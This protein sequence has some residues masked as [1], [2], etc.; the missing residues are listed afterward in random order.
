MTIPKEYQPPCARCASNSH[1]TGSHEALVRAYRD[2]YKRPVEIRAAVVKI[3]QQMRG[4]SD[5]AQHPVVVSF[6]DSG[7]LQLI[8]HTGLDGRDRIRHLH[9]DFINT[10]LPTE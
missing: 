8:V 2:L 6:D 7:D 1:S 4:W 10:K 5:V 3:E 9:F